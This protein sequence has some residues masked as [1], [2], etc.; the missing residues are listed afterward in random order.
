MIA[1]SSSA[2]MAT[3]GYTAVAASS[4]A[5]VAFLLTG[6]GRTANVFNNPAAVYLGQISY[7]LYLWHFPI[8]FMVGDKFGSRWIS[9]VAVIVATVIVASASYFFLERPLIRLA[10]RHQ[11]RVSGRHRVTNMGA[12]PSRDV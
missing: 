9:T 5:L 12:P 2:M 4:A 1:N 11:S 10:R 3:V 8:I 7:G 6:S